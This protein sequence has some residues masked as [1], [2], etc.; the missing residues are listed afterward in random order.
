MESFKYVIIGNSAA[1]IAACEGIRKEDKEGTI[2]VISYEEMGPYSRCLISYYIA[3]RVD[4]EGILFRPGS[5][6]ES[7]KITPLLGKRVVRI[8]PSGKKVSLDDGTE[9][10]FEMLLIATGASAVVYD[11]PGHDKE[12]V[13]VLRSYGDAVRISEAV[14]TAQR[15]AIL[16]GGLVGLKATEA[17]LARGVEPYMIISSSQ[18]M[19]QTMDKEGADILEARL[20]ANGVHVMT[21]TNVEEI[22]GKDRVKRVLLD[23]GQELDV[24]MVL[25]A[26]GVYPN[27]G[28]AVEAGI[29]T[30]YGILVDDHM[31]TNIPEIYAAG[32][33]AEALD[34]I[35][36]ERYSHGIWPNAVE[37]GKIAGMNMA[38]ADIVYEGGFGMNSV[39]VFGLPSISVGMVR[40]R[41]PDESIEIL[42]EKDAEH[43]YYRKV[44]LKNGVLIGAI[45]I[46]RV[47]SAGVYGEL[48]R[49]RVNVS[50]IKDILMEEDFNY[51]RVL[52]SKVIQDD[53]F[54]LRSDELALS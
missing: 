43:G 54:F 16:G 53:G 9:V 41:D 22:L 2:A 38:G 24:D 26:K 49:R 44:V 48:I 14:G 15:A 36:G 10:G 21:R 5:F 33:V 18:V 40:I 50:G 34:L 52:E 6:Y 28:I 27:I 32:D 39:D 37:Q 7:Q 13:F 30:N 47:E 19:S 17:L 12:G 23:S 46:G 20:R 4:E 31:R 11:M 42:S 3:G 25:F 35:T 51:A 1:G 29:E 45:C 8:D